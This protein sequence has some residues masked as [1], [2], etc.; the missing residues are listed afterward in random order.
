MSGFSYNVGSLIGVKQGT[1]LGLLNLLFFLAQIPL[2]KKLGLT[3]FFQVLMI[4]V[5]TILTN[6]FIY[7]FPWI[8]FVQSDYLAQ[9]GLMLSGI[10]VMALG[11][12]L[13]M[14]LDFVFMPFEGF[15]HLLSH[16]LGRSFGSVRRHLDLLLV[17]LSLV[18]ML[19]SHHPNTA[20]REGTILFAL[21]VGTLNHRL[22]PTL[23]HW[24]WKDFLEN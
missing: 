4:V 5:S 15:I 24:G 2:L 16:R 6:L 7:D 18:I 20:V 23:K 3:H 11:V 14:V 8:P 1:A 10:G 12:A 13:M 9:L 17:F 21:L 19:V 22:M